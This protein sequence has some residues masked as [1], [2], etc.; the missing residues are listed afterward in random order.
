[1]SSKAIITEGDIVDADVAQVELGRCL[2]LRVTPAAARDLYRLTV[3]NQ[4]RRLVLTLNDVALGARKIDGPFAEGTV[5]VFVEVTD[6][7]LT[8]LVRDLKRTSAELQ[9]EI[10][11]KS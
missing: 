10:A 8:A 3:L 7:E 11:R 1:M 2:L 6:A 9:K 4:G 5:L